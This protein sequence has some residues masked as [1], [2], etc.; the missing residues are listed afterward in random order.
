[1][2][3]KIEYSLEGSYKVDLYSGGKLVQEGNWMTNFIT[4]TGLMYPIIYPFIDCFQF[5]SIGTDARNNVAG[6]LSGNPTTG[7]YAPITSFQTSQGSGSGQWIGYEGYA[8]VLGGGATSCGTQITTLG[9]RFFR[10]WNIPTGAPNGETI[11]QA[12]GM[13][14]INEFAVSPSSGSDQTGACAFSRINR[15]VTI[16]NNQSA[17][18]SYQLAVNLQNTGLTFFNSGTFQTGQANV[19]NDTNIISGWANLSGYYR[20]VYFGL[21]IIDENG[22]HCILNEGAGM[23]PSM[24]NFQGYI[25]YLSPD[26]S[27]FDINNTTGIQTLDYLSY[28]GDGLLQSLNT[29]DAG[30]VGQTLSP[31]QNYYNYYY[32]PAFPPSQE[33]NNL[34]NDI[35]IGGLN[36]SFQLP[37]VSNYSVANNFNS[38]N[39]LTPIDASQLPIS[40]ATPGHFGF[41]NSLTNFKQK[42]VFSSRI[43]RLPFDPSRNY[44]QNAT[45]RKKTI[46]RKT[47]FPAISALGYNTRFGSLVYSYM[48]GYSP[49]T[50]IQSQT[51]T[52]YPMIDTLFYDS[53]GRSLMQH[54]RLISGI[55]LTERGSGI[56]DA[57]FFL[58]PSGDNTSRFNKSIRTFQGGYNSTNITGIDTTSPAL[59]TAIDTTLYPT[60]NY[61]NYYWNNS[62]SQSQG[63]VSG[64]LA[65]GPVN[66]N[67][68]GNSKTSVSG[69][70]GWGAV[71][72]LLGNIDYFGQYYDCGLTEHNVIISGGN[73]T[74]IPISPPSNTGTIYWPSILS[75]NEIKLGIKNVTF[76][77]PEFGT[78]LD[79]GW[80][81]N[82]NQIIE[83]VTFIDKDNTCNNG[84]LLNNGDNQQMIH[85]PTGFTNQTVPITNPS[86]P[87]YNSEYG[88]FLTTIKYNYSQIF[89][90]DINNFVCSNNNLG[91]TGY[92]DSLSTS[93][94]CDNGGR[95]SI[96][97][98]TGSV[99]T[100]IVP[101]IAEVNSNGFSLTNA[102]TIT[103]FFANIRERGYINGLNGNAINAGANL[104]FYFSGQS[105]GHPLYITYLQNSGAGSAVIAHSYLSPTVRVTSFM[106]P[107][108]YIVHTEY[109]RNPNILFP[110]SSSVVS[111]T[112][113][114]LLP[115][116]GLPN[117]NGINN[118]FPQ[119]GGELPGL[120][121]DN[122]LELYQDVTFSSPCASNDPTCVNPF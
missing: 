5:L 50:A 39:Y 86:N 67:E 10:A 121:T 74:I 95:S 89:A 77:S 118:Y 69:G 56:S 82:T 4:Q 1:M 119:I 58:Y 80:F 14:T 57:N 78:I 93:S 92:I 22:A 64:V 110:T 94:C 18:I 53:S 41:N 6:I 83:K 44:N 59:S 111:I 8:T 91:L 60:S 71:Y 120:S 115:N 90:G 55:Y 106:R 7:V 54:Y 107:T 27:Q 112:G 114:R 25:F 30:V 12:A 104:E 28:S 108:G 66:A 109:I 29:M 38:E 103:G 117:N 62:S 48:A 105:G 45:G 19:T 23:E 33:N 32:G 26:N 85:N 13:L 34:P 87:V 73:L 47:I 16:P 36:S 70:A 20:Q 21:E 42:A 52:F 99:L 49:G 37:D 51:I 98:I 65:N 17:I 97:S 15:T 46:T 76:Y 81:S 35:R 113:Y 72:G 75:G 100:S 84:G 61:Y 96:N 63:A 31:G 3:Q 116:Y 2:R 88:Y 9:P 102:I 68:F 43:F 11:Q 79:T 101:S 122:V 40:Y 24:T